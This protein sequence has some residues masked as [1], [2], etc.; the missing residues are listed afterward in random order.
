MDTQS[1]FAAGANYEGLKNELQNI[2]AIIEKYPDQLKQRAFELLINAYLGRSNPIETPAEVAPEIQV[3][4][5]EEDAPREEI[6]AR[7]SEILSEPET[8]PEVEAAADV[9]EEHA[10][11][12]PYANRLET[13]SP[14]ST[15]EDT[16]ANLLRKRIRLRSMSQVRWQTQ[17]PF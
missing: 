14:F 2:A 11:L 17:S 4:H 5:A 13:A 9:P 7:E 8:S 10:P 6:S 3:P 12:D 15:A 16:A 1:P